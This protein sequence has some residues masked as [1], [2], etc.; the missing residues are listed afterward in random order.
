LRPVDVSGQPGR[1]GSCGHGTDALQLAGFRGG[2]CFIQDVP[3]PGPMP[4]DA[5]EDEQR[6]N[7][8]GAVSRMLEHLLRQRAPGGTVPP[9]VAESKPAH[10]VQTVGLEVVLVEYSRPA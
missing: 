1:L 3:D 2:P 10:H 5:P 9:R 8:A 4:R 6:L 7:P